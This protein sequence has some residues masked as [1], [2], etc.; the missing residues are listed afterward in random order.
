MEEGNYTYIAIHCQHQDDSC[1]KMG[2]DESRFNVSLI[3]RDK[4]HTVST[5]HNFG[6]ERKAQAEPERKSFMRAV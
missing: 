5:D 2:S 1:V 6:R 3:V 4:F